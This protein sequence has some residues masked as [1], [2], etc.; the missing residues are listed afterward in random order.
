MVLQVLGTNAE[1][2][3]DNLSQTVIRD[4]KLSRSP[5]VEEWEFLRYL[6]RERGYAKGLP[7]GY[8]ECLGEPSV[9]APLSLAC[10]V[11][12]L[13]GVDEYS[14]G[15]SEAVGMVRSG[16]VRPGQARAIGHGAAQ[17]R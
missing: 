3:A 6:N 7:V 8:P 13:C 5:T 14:P 16:P 12:L 17:S 9:G 4:G 15:P 1:N 11:R 2:W 10:Q